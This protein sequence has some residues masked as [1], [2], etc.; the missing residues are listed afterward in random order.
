[1]HKNDPDPTH[2]RAVYQLVQDGDTY[3]EVSYGHM[4][5]TYVQPGQY[6]KRVT[7]SGPLETPAPSI[8]TLCQSRKRSDL[9]DHMRVLTCAAPKCAHSA[10]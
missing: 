10:A 7:S 3:Y 1:M 6:L 5:D 9:P 8:T 4:N 2:Y